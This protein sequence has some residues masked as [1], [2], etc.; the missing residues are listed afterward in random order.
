MKDLENEVFQIK[1]F[2]EDEDVEVQVEGFI[3]DMG[4]DRTKNS[5]LYHTLELYWHTKIM[6]VM[7]ML[8]KEKDFFHLKRR[9]E[10][11]DIK[12]CI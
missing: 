9:H 7:G 11:L 10:S 3:L 4:C 6:V 8:P 12:M 1:E 5:N 2:Q